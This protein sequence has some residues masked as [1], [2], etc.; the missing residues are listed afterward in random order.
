MQYRGTVQQQASPLKAR[1]RPL[2]ATSLRGMPGQTNRAI[3]AL[4]FVAALLVVLGHLRNTMFQDYRDIE[5]GVVPFLLY[6]TTSLGNAAVLV[7][8]ALSGF[9]V[10]GAALAQRLGGTFSVR[11][12]SIARLT[13]LWLVLLPALALT[14][15]VDFVGSKVFSHADIYTHPELYTGVVK[16]PSH[17]LVTLLGNIFFVQDLHVEPFGYNKPLWSLSYEFW[18][19]AMFAALLVATATRSSLR[20]RLIAVVVAGAGAAI[21]GTTVLVLFPVW[22]LGVVAAWKA[23]AAAR[24]VARRKPRRVAFVRGAALVML[25]LVMMT[26]R[27]GLGVGSG[28]AAATIGSCIFGAIAAFQLWTISPDVAW[29]GLRSRVLGWLSWLAESSYSLY[30]THMPL[31]VLIGAALVPDKDDRWDLVGPGY[32]VLLLLASLLV[33]F[34]VVFAHFTEHRTSEVRRWV[35]A[36]LTTSE[37]QPATD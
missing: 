2:P 28:I 34:S 25:L 31:V 22:L 4:R 11:E 17:S 24:W 8:F 10:G 9:W 12:Y 21:S 36:Q 37:P 15:L 32:L 26:S 18:Y 20:T 29:T 3:N 35:R 14:A 1:D 5:H 6:L 23:P 16:E 19:Y 30:A 7:F 13:R 27:A 33:G